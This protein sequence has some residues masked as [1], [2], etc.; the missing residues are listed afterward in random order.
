LEVGWDCSAW[1]GEED[2]EKFL[3][4]LSEENKK[5]RTLHFQT[6]AFTAVSGRP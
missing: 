4:N 2:E 1:R 3:L 5:S 6:A